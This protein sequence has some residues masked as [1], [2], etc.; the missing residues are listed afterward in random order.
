MPFCHFINIICPLSKATV[1]RI[2]IS[3]SQVRASKKLSIVLSRNIYIFFKPTFEGISRKKSMCALLRRNGS[4][5]HLLET[6]IWSAW[7]TWG[8]ISSKKSL[9]SLF[10]P[11]FWLLVFSCQDPRGQSTN[12]LQQRP[13]PSWCRYWALTCTSDDSRVSLRSKQKNGTNNSRH[14]HP[15]EEIQNHHKQ[16]SKRRSKSSIPISTRM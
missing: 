4:S 5:T 8:P 3:F 2:A 1:L 11:I 16:D 12:R 9:S 10:S 13:S 14:W 7:K 15:Y 6:S